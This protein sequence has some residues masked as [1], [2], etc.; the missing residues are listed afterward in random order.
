MTRDRYINICLRAAL[1]ESL[2][3]LHHNNHRF[4]F[5]SILPCMLS[6]TSEDFGIVD[7]FG[8]PISNKPCWRNQ[9]DELFGATMSP[10]HLDIHIA[11]TP[12]RW[13]A[14]YLG[15]WREMFRPE[16]LLVFLAVKGHFRYIAHKTP[17]RSRNRLSFR[18]VHP[19]SHYRFRETG[20][21]DENRPG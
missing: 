8:T 12:L 5:F 4:D 2:P 20:A 14:I 16:L 18:E 6:D 15:S 11:V 7:N 1:P 17:S 13:E 3:S 21:E 10:N 9:S 19:W